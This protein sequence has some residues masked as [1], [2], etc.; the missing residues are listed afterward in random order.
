MAQNT[1]GIVQFGEAT[2]NA[3]VEAR[4]N[5]EDRRLIQKIIVLHIYY[6]LH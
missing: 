2:Q 5:K 6:M 4:V 1:K 3:K